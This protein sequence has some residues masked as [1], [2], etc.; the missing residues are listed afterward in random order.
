MYLCAYLVL[1][2]AVSLS[3]DACCESQL[4][5]CR[6]NLFASALMSAEEVIAAE[7]FAGECHQCGA[8]VKSHW[9]RCPSCKAPV[10]KVRPQMPQTNTP[11]PTHACTYTKRFTSF[12][13]GEATAST[14]TDIDPLTLDRKP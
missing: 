4:T 5:P 8:P 7:G 12:P 1:F 13:A 10:L 2:L 6:L 11:A 9:P 3:V 14:L